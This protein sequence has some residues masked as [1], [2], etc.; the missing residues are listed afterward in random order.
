MSFLSLAGV[1]L[2]NTRR[3]GIL[4]ILVIPVFLIWLT[5]VINADINFT[6]GNEGISPENNFFIQIFMGYA[7]FM[8]PASI[9]ISTVMLVQTERKNKG[10]LKMLALPVS[11]AR[12]CLVK[13]SILLLLAAVQMFF[14][15]L[16]YFPSAAIASRIQDYNFMLPVMDILR[17]AGIIYISSIPMAAFFWMLAVSIQ[18]PIFSMGVGMASIVPSVLLINTKIWFAYPMCYPFLMA[19][20]RMHELASNMGTFAFELMPF[21]PVAVGCTVV[22][23]FA[24]CIRFGQAERR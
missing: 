21:I 11:A 9:V 2:K 16:A 19:A 20:S 13:F 5:A 10:I 12:L 8:F 15:T 4:W 6:I 7:W 17:E 1:E 24:A 14:M 3:S 23:L 18:T 22:C